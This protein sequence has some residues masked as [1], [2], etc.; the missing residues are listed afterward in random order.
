MNKNRALREPLR[1]VGGLTCG[2]G[3]E[4]ELCFGEIKG[5]GHSLQTMRALANNCLQ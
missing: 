4:L 3:C 5:S 2:T 1:G